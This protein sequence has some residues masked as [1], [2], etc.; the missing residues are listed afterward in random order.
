M[1]DS[2]QGWYSKLKDGIWAA[3]GMC[4]VTLLFNMNSNLAVLGIRSDIQEENIN[5]NR[6]NIQE[7][8][9]KV[10]NAIKDIDIN[11][12]RLGVLESRISKKKLVDYE[13][14]FGVR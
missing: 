2:E 4:I 14:V 10:N 1:R 3:I 5:R 13:E 6:E 8:D 12:E 11:K 9:D 7:V